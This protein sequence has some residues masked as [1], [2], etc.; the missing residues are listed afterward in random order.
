MRLTTSKRT[1]AKFTRGSILRTASC[2]KTTS[3]VTPRSCLPGTTLLR[4]GA[5][6][7]QGAVNCTSSP[8]WDESK[9][10]TWSFHA[11]V[12]PRWYVYVGMSTEAGVLKRAA[13]SAI[14]PTAQVRDSQ[15]GPWTAVGA[16][17][18]RG[19]YRRVASRPGE[20]RFDAVAALS[21]ERRLDSGSRVSDQQL[22]S[23]I[24]AGPQ[25]CSST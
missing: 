2:L 25:T 23:G 13:L 18:D 3:P 9:E 5:R 15:L 6:H 17:D 7:R 24:R 8:A 1:P 16:H 19:S 11:I 4:G 10:F 14:H 22:C 20:Y 21:T 12:I